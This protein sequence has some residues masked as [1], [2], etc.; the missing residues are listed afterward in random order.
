MSK[1]L[2]KR[3]TELKVVDGYKL[4][5]HKFL[6]NDVE[7][8]VCTKKG[9]KAYMKVVVGRTL[10]S[11]LQHNHSRDDNLMRQAISNSCKRKATEDLYERPSKILC[12]EMTGSALEVLNEHDRTQI[13]KAIH[14]ARAKLRPPLPKNRGQLHDNLQNYIVQTKL[15]EAFLLV[16]DDV[17]NIIMFSTEKNLK[18][19]VKCDFLL[20]DGT[21]YSSPALFSQVFVIFGKKKFVHVP[22][23][24]F[25][26]PSKEEIAY[27]RA[28]R[29]LTVFLPTDYTPDLVYVDFEKAI[30]NAV[31]SVWRSTL[32]QGCRFHLGQSWFRRIQSLGLTKM[33]RSK[34]AEG[35]YLRVFFGLPFLDPTDMENFFE[36]ELQM[37]EPNH[38]AVKEFSKYVYENYVRPGALFPP[39]LWASY[40]SSIARTT[41]ACES[42][43]SKLNGQFYHAHPNIYL[44]IDALLEIQERTYSKMLSVH[45]K[46]MSKKS[47]LKQ[48]YIREA[49]DAFEEG[50][51][52]RYE[53][54]KKVS[55]KF[56]V[57]KIC[58]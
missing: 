21:F 41:N 45:I 28:L 38:P 49:M 12:K 36:Y 55:R 58:S 25:L 20:M 39:Y 30:H 43:N 33:Y 48:Q 31:E 53:F 29:K 34:T 23:V 5:F 54:V 52:D 15:P 44:F 32:I 2:S 3:G 24:F 14:S 1:M 7:R 47:A 9:C 57:K 27:E 42:F 16:N 8:W 6:A 40:S 13:R 51:I 26:L 11:D 50:R 18:F 56:L 4:R 37:K 46:K 35:S 17:N 22:L 10:E 19:L